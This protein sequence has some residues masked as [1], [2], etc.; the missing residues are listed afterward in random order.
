M[1]KILSINLEENLNL[2]IRLQIAS[3]V[4]LV[5]FAYLF[6]LPTAQRFSSPLAVL[7]QP[8][9]L[10]YRALDWVLLFLMIFITLILHELVHALLFKLLGPRKV[11]IVFGFSLGFAFA[12]APN[13]LFN[14]TRYLIVGIGPA[15]LI[16]AACLVLLYFLS[17]ATAPILFVIALVNASGSVG[18][19]YISYRV[20]KTPPGTLIRDTGTE[21][22]G[23]TNY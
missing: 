13:A 14:R 21:F 23:Y 4:L 10:P 12:A 6:Y 7:L 2:I 18:D 17:N 8:I 9:G 19:Y 11:H 15:V 5:P 16:S 20:F 1:K 3:L 22:I